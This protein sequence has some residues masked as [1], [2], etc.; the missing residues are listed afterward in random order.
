[1]FK[2][3]DYR[4]RIQA[5]RG[6][7]KEAGY[8]LDIEHLRPRLEEL[9]REQENP[10]VWQDLEKS[11][12]I[13]REIAQLRGKITAYEAGET[14]LNDAGDVID[15]IEETGDESLIAELDEMMAKA[16]K[17]IEEMRIRAILKGPYDS[18]N[19]MLALHAGAG[20][21]EAC[22]WCSML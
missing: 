9:E 16:E 11:T 14:L 12:K 21:T 5:L 15:L 7:L 1:M 2:A 19:A 10:D 8:A 4:L 17:D 6:L 3:D 13:G 22:D 20:G 18:H